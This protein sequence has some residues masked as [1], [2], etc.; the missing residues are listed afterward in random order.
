MCNSTCRNAD[1]YK[2]IW[3]KIVQETT[4]L[5]V[6]YVVNGDFCG[7]STKGSQGFVRDPTPV[8]TK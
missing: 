2:E 8:K 6:K 5:E 3:K 4:R 1:D 7:P